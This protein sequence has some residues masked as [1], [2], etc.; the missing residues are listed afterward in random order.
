M[1]SKRPFFLRFEVV[2]ILL[3]MVAYSLHW[4]AFGKILNVSGWALP[5][6]YRKSTNIS[7]TVLFFAKK[8]S[9]HLAKFMYIV[10]ALAL[11]SG[12]FVYRRKLRS[13]NFFLLLMSALGILV[14]LYMYFYFITSK[15]FKLSHAGIGIHLLLGISLVGFIYSFAYC[16]RKKKSKDT[17]TQTESHEQPDN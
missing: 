9:I 17:L 6:L 5:D 3:V 4:I 10:P 15:I 7:N 16:T 8:E 12:I 11:I 13:A 2:I 14:S 1:K